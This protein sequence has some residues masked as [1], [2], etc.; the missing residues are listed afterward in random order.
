MKITNKQYAQ[1]LFEATRGKSAAELKNELENFVKIL[2]V[3]GDVSRLETIL[4]EF[5]KVWQVEKGEV[6]ADVVSADRLEAETLSQIKDYVLSETGATEVNLKHHVDK[7]LLAGFILRFND[8]IVD[9]SAQNMISNLK[10]E[11]IK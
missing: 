11:L 5:E 1:S 2:A 7:D 9:G 3:N 6:Q 8:Q 10:K 4:T